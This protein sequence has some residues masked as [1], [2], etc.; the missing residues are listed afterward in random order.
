VIVNRAG[1]E[2]A[3]DLKRTIST[4]FEEVGLKVYTA[5]MTLSTERGYCLINVDGA[6]PNWPHSMPYLAVM[7][8]IGMDGGWSEAVEFRCSAAEDEYGLH[9]AFLMDR[10]RVP[11]HDLIEELRDTLHER[12]VVLAGLKAGIKPPFKFANA[13]WA[14]ASPG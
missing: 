2:P 13:T 6:D 11:L 5:S 7:A 1:R 8:F 10:R 9:G 4:A 12:E 3:E 14:T